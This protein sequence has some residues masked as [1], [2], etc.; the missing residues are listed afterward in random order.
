MADRERGVGS[1]PEGV[2]FLD[3]INMIY[4]IKRCWGLSP[5]GKY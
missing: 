1:V 5:G 4:R 3:R 2:E